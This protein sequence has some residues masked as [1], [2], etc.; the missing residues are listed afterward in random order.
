MD[1]PVVRRRA[2]RRIGK[3]GTSTWVGPLLYKLNAVD[4]SRLKGAWFQPS[5]LPWFQSLLS[6][7]QLVPLQLGCAAAKKE[8]EDLAR[9]AAAME[10]MLGGFGGGGSRAGGSSRGGRGGSR[11]RANP[12][13][14]PP[15]GMPAEAM[16]ALSGMA[17]AAGMAGGGLIIT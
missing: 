9:Q 14:T 5:T 8:F 4:P 1:A 3:T 16:A 13:V 6:S 11:A 2:R 7:T 10:G 17:G 12:S 15:P